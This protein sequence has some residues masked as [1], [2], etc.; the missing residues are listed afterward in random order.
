[1]TIPAEQ[2]LDDKARITALDPPVTYAPTLEDA[3]LPQTEDIVAAAKWL[4]AY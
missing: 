1:M 2:I 3:Y 4:L